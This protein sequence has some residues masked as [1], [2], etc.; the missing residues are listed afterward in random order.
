MAAV[1]P[2]GTLPWVEKYRPAGL[3]DLVS[4]EAV[5][6]TLQGFLDKGQLPHLLLYGPPGTGK[7]STI[8]A[9]ARRMYGAAAPH[10]VLELNASDDRGIDVVRHQIKDFATSSMLFARPG[11]VRLV[12]LD[13]AD[14]MTQDAQFALRRMIEAHAKRTRFCLICNNVNKVIPALH[15]RCTRFRFQ[16]LRPE[17]MRARV[18]AVAAAEGVRLTKSGL[19]ALLRLAHGDMRRV[20]NVL[21]ATALGYPKVNEAAVYA[22][23]G[24]PLPAHVQALTHALW[25]APFLEAFAL[26]KDMVHGRGYALCDLLTEVAAAARRTLASRPDAVAAA[27]LTALGQLEARLAVSVLDDVQVGS[28]VGVFVLARAAVE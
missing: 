27:L 2:G 17:L 16:L 24:D 11:D 21:Q 22:C 8:L 1:G 7:T 10:M 25:H 23:T 26:A 3:E 4:Q 6:A 18:A 15:S 9:C 5:V 13:E 20:L 28:L 14:A 19:E 12:V